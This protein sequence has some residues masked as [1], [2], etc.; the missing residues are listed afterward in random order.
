MERIP[1]DPKELEP[2]GYIPAP[3]PGEAPTPVF[4][5]PI[6]RKENFRLFVSGQKPLW[7]PHVREFLLLNPECVPDSMARGM[8]SKAGPVDPSKF[9]GKDMFG[10]EWEYVP[11]VRGSI[12][13]P[14]A[15]AVTDLEHWEDVITF[16]DIETWDWAGSAEE[17]KEMRSDGRIIKVTLF[18]GLFERLI[19]FVDMT[20]ALVS[21]IDEDC[22]PAI[23]RLFDR[24]CVLYDGMFEKFK[25]YFDADIVWFHDDWGSQQAPFFSPATMREMVLPYLKR[26]VDSAHKYGMAFELHSC[27]KIEMLAP[28]MVEAGCDMW[29]GQEM[30]DKIKVLQLYGDKLICDSYPEPYSADAAPE[31]KAAVVQRYLDNYAGLRTYT[32]MHHGSPADEYQY[33]YELSRKA[34]N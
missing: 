22:Q 24:L 14:G 31:E 2:L 3:F 13:R 17:T 23:H 10:I 7:M 8:V 29:N 5:T 26:I 25:T 11:S 33:V 18:S 30:N 20:D 28:I 15:P 6:S 21:M 27:G 9:G 32:G 1:F 16:P 4:N 19:S 34:Y 12:V